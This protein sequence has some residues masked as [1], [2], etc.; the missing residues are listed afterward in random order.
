MTT[1]KRTHN[2]AITF[3]RPM[4]EKAARAYLADAMRVVENFEVLCRA[5][6]GYENKTKIVKTVVRRK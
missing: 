1:K 3:S 6:W 4:S 2:L 5:A